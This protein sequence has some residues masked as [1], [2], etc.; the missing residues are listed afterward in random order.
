MFGLSFHVFSVD[1]RINHELQVQYPTYMRHIPK[2]LGR[3]GGLH[4]SLND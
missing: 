2:L 3:F 4:V 1:I